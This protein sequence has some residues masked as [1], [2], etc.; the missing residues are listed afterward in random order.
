M[1]IYT[2]RGDDGTAAGFLSGA[3]VP[4]SHRRIDAFGDLDE[5][6][7]ALAVLRALVSK[8]NADLDDEIMRIQS[9]VLQASAWLTTWQDPRFPQ[10][11]EEIGEQHLCFLE[12]AIDRILERLPDLN[13]FVIP[14]DHFFA[15][16]AH[17][18]RAICR[19]AERDM[20]RLSAE[21]NGSDPSR[22]LQGITTYLNRLSDY[23]FVLARYC[24]YLVGM[25]EDTLWKMG[26]RQEA[27][28][29]KSPEA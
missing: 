19:R 13:S 28:E 18:A 24:N 3:R 22:Q 5:L 11:F 8:Q 26:N 12:S 27:I 20:V 9:H 2:R 17:I 10:R 29:H 7:C 16:L 15:A 21:D 6:N 4:K 14:G 23:L 1:K 25:P